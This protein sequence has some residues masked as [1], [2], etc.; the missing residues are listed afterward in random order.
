LKT[1]AVVPVGNHDNRKDEKEEKNDEEDK[2]PKSIVP[3]GE[4]FL[5]D[6]MGEIDN[7]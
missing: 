5:D 6:C 2:S 3:V 4:S 7:F 1:K